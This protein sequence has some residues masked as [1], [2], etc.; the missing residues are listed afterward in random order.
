MFLAII[1][2]I[3]TYQGDMHVLVLVALLVVILIS[4]L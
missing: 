4:L 3:K 1:I 2:H